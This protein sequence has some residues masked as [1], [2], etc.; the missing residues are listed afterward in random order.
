MALA[1]TVLITVLSLIS[2][3]NQQPSAI[4]YKDKMVHFVFYF[5]FIL[6][7]FRFKKSESH[8]KKTGLLIF[9]IAVGYGVLM[10]ICQSAFT[11]TRSADIYDVIAN[12]LGA[13]SGLILINYKLLNKTQL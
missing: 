4:P 3:N 10:E 2:L 7:W 1:W 5:V 9:V 8:N 13:L 12:S 6:L 11:T